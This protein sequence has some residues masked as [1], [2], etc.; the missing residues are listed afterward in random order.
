M[1]L[2]SVLCPH[3]VP[4]VAAAVLVLASFGL[5]G[6]SVVKAA[7]KVKHDLDGNKATIDAFTGKMQ[8]VE[9]S[10]F[11]ATYVT[12]GSSPAT[13]VYAVQP[14]NGLSFTDSAAG[15]GGGAPG[16][17]LV[18]NASGEYSCTPPSGSGATWSCQK[19]GTASAA[20]ENKIFDF[21]TP[22]HWVGF[23]KD[24]SLAAGIAGD[25][26]TTSTMAVNG[27]SMNCVD[28]VAP[29]VAGTST[30][31]TTAQGILGYVQVASSATSFEIKSYSG[32]P[33][34]SLFQLPP[35]ATVVTTPPASTPTVNS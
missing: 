16:V 19:L 4:G 27:F 8:S 23:L 33:P 13:V 15:S 14:P 12:T 20:A 2:P 18:V 22:A 24:F 26:V 1:V 9:A 34:S 7:E 6:C 31:C 21:Y 17:D 32:S 25:K 11:E 3:R 10:P 35:G 29:G 28:F 5:S 30:I